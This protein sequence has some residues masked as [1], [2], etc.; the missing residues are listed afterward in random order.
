MGIFERMGRIA[1]ANFNS[2]LDSADSPEKSL[3][4]TLREMREQLRAA[5][6]EVVRGLAAEKQL[7]NKVADIGREVTRWESRAELA[8]RHGKDELARDALAQK[9]RLAAEQA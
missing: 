9:R 7:R 6:R 3:D 8:V 1:S 4:L 2:L 5:R